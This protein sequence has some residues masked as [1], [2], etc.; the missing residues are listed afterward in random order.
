M[1]N[2][3]Q[4]IDILELSIRSM[5]ALK[6]YTEINTIK[7]L[8]KSSKGYL[9]RTPNFCRLSLKEGE[10]SLSL[11]DL[12]LGMSD[13]DLLK[14]EP[15]LSS[16]TEENNTKTN[17]NGKSVKYNLNYD[18]LKVAKEAFIKS[19]RRIIYKTDWTSEE[20]KD[21]FNDHQS[22]LNTYRQSLYELFY[23]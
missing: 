1:T 18:I 14:Y 6:K 22:V 20:V 19:H 16:D 21:F 4:S 9:L 5:N 10:E 17:G 15:P 23:N 3:N 13:E 12:K 11:I 8:V 7:D 2:L